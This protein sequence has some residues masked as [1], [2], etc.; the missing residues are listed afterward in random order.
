MN[1]GQ[2]LIELSNGKRV[3]RAGWN[4]KNMFLLYIDPYHND[5]F[6]VIE[7]PGMV[8]TLVSYIALKTVDNKLVPWNASQ[9][10]ALATDWEIVA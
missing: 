3:A 6:Q 9:A 7:K 2:A 5:Q 1:F 10:D 4:G 8:G